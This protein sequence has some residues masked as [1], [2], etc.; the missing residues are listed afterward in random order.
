MSRTDAFLNSGPPAKGGLFGVLGLLMRV[1]G[2]G[3]C[4]AVLIGALAI[5]FSLLGAWIEPAD[6]V[7]QFRHILIAGTLTTSVIG[8]L[9][10]RRIAVLGIF[11]CAI[12]L[13]AMPEVWPSGA[14]ESNPDTARLLQLNLRWTNTDFDA[15]EALIAREQ[16]DFIAL[17]EVSMHNEGVLDVLRA[18]YPA[19]IVCQSSRVMS[20]AILSKSAFVEAPMCK[21][22]SGWTSARIAIGGVYTTLISTH[23]HWPWPFGQRHQV[24]HMIEDIAGLNGPFIVAGDFNAAAWTQ[25]V[26]RIAGATDTQAIGG[27]R[28]TFHVSEFHL[29]LA[30]DHILV[31]GGAAKIRKLGRAGSD[32]N[33][34]VADLTLPEN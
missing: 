7:A 33:A 12:G 32:H 19:Q 17:Q 21:A 2:F 10:R 5:M 31:P 20:V 1:L 4:A 23:L 22:H 29:P 24:D 9:V 34:S 25:S 8:L 28:F 26:R 15:V 27:L 14:P 16:P 13:A 30:I 6:S 3:I 18:D 11:C